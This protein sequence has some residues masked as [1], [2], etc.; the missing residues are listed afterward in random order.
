[1]KAGAAEKLVE[2]T[3]EFL[4]QPALLLRHF[5]LRSTCLDQLRGF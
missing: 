1:M 2:G 5:P 4:S 3:P